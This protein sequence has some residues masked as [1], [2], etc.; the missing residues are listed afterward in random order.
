MK[1]IYIISFFLI[2]LMSF[3]QKKVIK[4]FET[5]AK[6]IEISTVGLDDF[7][8]ENSTSNFI[9]ITLF[10][11]NSN[12]Q[13]IVFNKKNNV[14]QIEFQLQTI[15]TEETVFRKFITKRLQ[16]AFAVVKIPKG[17]K[18][19]IFG[20]NI[21]IESKNVKNNLSIFIEKGILKLNTIKENT[22]VKL[23]AGTVY[24]TLQKT[25]SNIISNIGKIEVN[26][27]HHS[28]KYE[29]SSLENKKQ[30][31]ITSIKANIFLTTR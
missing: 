2:S 30:L 25:N 26:G 31:A 7:V 6:E 18:I 8:L 9:E 5:N 12:Q 29:N 24:A 19:S 22:T 17:K 11:E 14:A 16:R 4:K 13:H 15:K 27:V 10:A 20:E 21:N 3:S 28:K 23:Y 1:Q